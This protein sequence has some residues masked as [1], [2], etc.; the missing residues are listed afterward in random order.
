MPK[1]KQYAVEI[2]ERHQHGRYGKQLYFGMYL[3]G[4][5]KRDAE[6]IGI[7]TLASM[8]FDEIKSRCIDPNRMYPWECWHQHEHESK[9]G[10]GA[11]IGLD[12]AETF[13][14]C[15]AYIE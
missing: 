3:P 8:S 4:F 12:L 9:H 1:E 11:P 6:E 13:F 5:S 2:L 14:S 10:A 15:K 7:E